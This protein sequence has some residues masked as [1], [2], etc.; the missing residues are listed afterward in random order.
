[1]NLLDEMNYHAELRQD[2]FGK[3]RM[4]RASFKK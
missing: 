2:M 4:I 3:D 1:M